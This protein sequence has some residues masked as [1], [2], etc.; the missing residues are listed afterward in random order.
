MSTVMKNSI[1][2]D[3]SD[4]PPTPPWLKPPA[5]YKSARTVAAEKLR[6]IA[7]ANAQISHTAS[8]PRAKH[9]RRKSSASSTKKDNKKPMPPVQSRTATAEIPRTESALEQL[10]RT[11]SGEMMNDSCHSYPIIIFCCSNVPLFVVS[12]AAKFVE[13]MVN[14]EAQSGEAQSKETKLSHLSLQGSFEAL[15][16]LD[17][18]SVENLVNLASTSNLSS[19]TTDETKQL[20]KSIEEIT[21]TKLSSRMESFIKSLSSANLLKGGVSSSDALGGLLANLQNSL[22]DP[23]GSSSDIFDA[24]KNG[25]A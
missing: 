8:T 16:S 4:R 23:H 1:L 7:N 24:G 22:N 10:A 13:D 5:K 6:A 12:S 20:N 18:N 11:A 14:G 3:D 9:Q 17:M 21:G 15:M 19:D 2:D 25:V